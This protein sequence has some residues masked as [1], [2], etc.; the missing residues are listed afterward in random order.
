[1]TSASYLSRFIDVVRDNDGGVFTTPDVEGRHRLVEYDGW[2]FAQPVTLDFTETE[3]DDAI[4]TLARS[5]KELWPEVPPTDAGLRL[6]LVHLTESMATL[7]HEP[8]RMY[9]GVS[10]LMVG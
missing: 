10:G 8:T 4:K 2:R 5:G 1:L 6:A 9:F 3:F 7:K